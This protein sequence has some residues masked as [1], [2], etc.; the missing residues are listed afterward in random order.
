ME[1]IKTYKL[2][3]KE[4]LGLHSLFIGSRR[5]LPMNSWIEA[6]APCDEVLKDLPTGFALISIP[7]QFVV[8]IQS[9]RP[10]AYQV[11]H[12][13]I[14]FCRWVEVRETKRGTRIY[15]LGISSDG[16]VM[17]FAHRPGWHTSAEP[18][19]PGVNMDGKVW[20]ECLIPKKG[21]YI[22]RVNVS[23]L[24]KHHEP[25]EWYISQKLYITRLMEA[26]K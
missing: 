18:V 16:R 22:H 5:C 23:G 1:T 7:H 21:T 6:W 19:L 4:E 11:N 9:K 3:R 10:T 15:D 8:T 12:D 17:P 13:Q 25:L 26:T 14:R 20:A 2:L 24:T